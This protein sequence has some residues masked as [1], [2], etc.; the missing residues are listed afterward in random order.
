MNEREEEENGEDDTIIGRLRYVETC[1]QEMNDLLDEASRKLLQYKQHSTSVGSTTTKASLTLL[2]DILSPILIAGDLRTKAYQLVHSFHRSVDHGGNT[3]QQQLQLISLRLPLFWGHSSM[4]KADLLIKSSDGVR[5]QS[6]VDIPTTS[7]R[8]S[9]IEKSLGQAIDCHQ[10]TLSLI[11][12]WKRDRKEPTRRYL[13]NSSE[14]E[15]EDD[16]TEKSDTESC[17]PVSLLIESLDEAVIHFE[18]ARALSLKAHNKVEW[19]EFSGSQ[20]KDSQSGNRLSTIYCDSFELCCQAVE[21]FRLVRSLRRSSPLS[22]LSHT[23]TSPFLS[24]PMSRSLSQRLLTKDRNTLNV[25]VRSAWFS[26]SS[27]VSSN[28]STT[29]RNY[30]NHKQQ[31]N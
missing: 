25:S 27:R 3:I 26:S 5:D 19:G 9:T 2:D 6:K 22:N 14:F 24:L 29:P 21:A 23:I 8:F 7:Q 13:S 30:P 31:S 10:Q 12:E 18:L 16:N 28:R 4:L 1:I 20:S 17:N 15:E 11:T